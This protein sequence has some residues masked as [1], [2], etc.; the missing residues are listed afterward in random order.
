MWQICLLDQAEIISLV[1]WYIAYWQ[2]N[3]SHYPF[4]NDTTQS[5]NI[6]VFFTRFLVYFGVFTREKWGAY[7]STLCISYNMQMSI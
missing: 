4:T 2:F 5:C 1:E 6:V 7:T 3:M